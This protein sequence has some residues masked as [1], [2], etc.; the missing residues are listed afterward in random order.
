M[1]KLV[2]GVISVKVKEAR[3]EVDFFFFFF[4]GV[5]NCMICA[6]CIPCKGAGITQARARLAFFT[7][8]HS[9]KRF[10]FSGSTLLCLFLPQCKATIFS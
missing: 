10:F 7:R 8:R 1:L 5:D 3:E 4:C 6:E 9:A 2:P